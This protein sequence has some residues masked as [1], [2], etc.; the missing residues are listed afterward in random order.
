MLS[1]HSATL[2]GFVD[3]S[4]TMYEKNFPHAPLHTFGG[5]GARS[6]G[7][8]FQYFH[9]EWQPNKDFSFSQFPPGVSPKDFRHVVNKSANPL[10]ACFWG[11]KFSIWNSFFYWLGWARSHGAKFQYFHLEWQ[12]NEDFSFP[13]FSPGVSP[14]DFWHVVEKSANPLHASFFFD[15]VN[16]P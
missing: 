10:H 9:L 16:S 5:H 6:N 3:T 1:R 7:A 15:G 4:N 14:K 13:Q 8:K 2:P 11:R 12:P